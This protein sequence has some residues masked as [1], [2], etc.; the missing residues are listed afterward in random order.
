MTDCLQIY[1]GQEDLERV[2][3]FAL[4]TGEKLTEALSKGKE[5]VY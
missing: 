5:S 1:L 2:Y 4:V 3:N